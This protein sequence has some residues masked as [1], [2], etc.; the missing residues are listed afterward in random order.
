MSTML[1]KLS[2]LNFYISYPNLNST[3][4]N[5]QNEPSPHNMVE[6]PK[7]TIHNSS[8]GSLDLKPGTAALILIATLKIT[9]LLNQL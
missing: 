5:M 1:L 4:L 9:C 3:H 6:N 2:G 7:I 8:F